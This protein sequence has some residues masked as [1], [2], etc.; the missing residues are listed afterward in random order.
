MNLTGPIAAFLTG[1]YSV[2]RKARA[3]LDL[4]GDP[5]AGTVTTVSVRGCAQPST[6]RDLMRLP[7]GLRTNE[8]LALWSLDELKTAGGSYEPDSVSIDGESYQVASV[9]RWTTGRYWKALVVKVGNG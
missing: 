1:T 9:E 8:V 4:N 5:V 3:T 2:T 6:G 7:E